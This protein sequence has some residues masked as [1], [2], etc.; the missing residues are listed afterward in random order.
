[1]LIE[2]PSHN[3]L[4]IAIYLGTVVEEQLLRNSC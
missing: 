4:R 3:K 2:G 1:M